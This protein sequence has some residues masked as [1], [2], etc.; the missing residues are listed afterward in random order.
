MGVACGVDNLATTFSCARTLF[1]AAS[2]CSKAADEASG[3]EEVIP[4]SALVET[5]S[6]TMAVEAV[7]VKPLI[8]GSVGWF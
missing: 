1:L 3:M 7:S 8:S 6:Q 4:T 5:A 2:V